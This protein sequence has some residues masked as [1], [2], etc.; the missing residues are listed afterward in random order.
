MNIMSYIYSCIVIFIRN[1][2]KKKKKG[3][4]PKDLGD[5]PHQLG[6]R[7]REAESYG[8]PRH[9]MKERETILLGTEEDQR[10]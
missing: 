8:L 6:S 2:K 5:Y 1:M 3:C 9:L 4:Y 7:K 10:L